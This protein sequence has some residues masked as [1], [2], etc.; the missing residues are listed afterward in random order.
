M[1]TTSSIVIENTSTNPDAESPIILDNSYKGDDLTRRCAEIL[2][3]SD[4]QG[5]S[6]VDSE[7][8]T[9]LVHYRED[10]DKTRYGHIRGLFLDLEVG[11]IIADSFGYTPTAVA[12]ELTL[13]D[14]VLTV[15]DKEGDNHV[16]SLE[17]AV[18]KRVFEGVVIRVIW[19]K[20]VMRRITH[21]KINPCKSRWG[22]SKSFITM[23]D[24]A[25]GPTAEQL[26]DTSKPYSS[27]CYDFLV[28]DQCLLVGT[29]QIVT[30]PYIVCFACRTMDIK[31]PTEETAPG[32]A[33]FTTTDITG[34]LI[35]GSI[36]HDPKCLSL[37]EANH[38]LQFGY[39]SP[40]SIDDVRQLT[41]EA[42]I[43]YK[44]TDDVVTDIVKVHSPSYEWRVNMRGNNPNI[45]NQFY[46]LLNSVYG[47][48]NSSD[49]WNAFKGKFITLPLYDE[50]SLKD[51]YAQNH[52]ILTI[53]SGETSSIDYNTRDS[54]IHLLWMN[55][56]LS[57]PAHIQGDGLNI[58][59]NFRTDRND[60]VTWLQNLEASN[61]NIESTEFSERVKGLI[62]SSRKLARA[63][64]SKGENY[65]A[66][67]S[68]MR[69]PVLIK[70]TL[71]NL[72]NKEKGPS[73]YSLVREMKLARK[74]ANTTTT[75][76]AETTETTSVDTPAVL[77]ETIV[78][79][80]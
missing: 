42:V 16:F 12:S 55:Y 33:T 58:L 15:L 57:L 64:I 9:A 29:R 49:L 52:V 7:E 59:S 51:L 18:I 68:Y 46:S 14:G 60:L 65:S 13:S 79:A 76:T 44:M 32:L 63:R 75:D 36:I 19:R 48:I 25:G 74:T 8:D 43:I 47:D 70:T 54:R 71:R 39:Y 17:E 50:Q 67:G 3:I 24:E 45:T 72:I 26:F 37:D 61:K 11:A 78:T 6:V 41:G 66:K 31:R 1:A 27:T 21:R 30:S 2:G 34:G 62:I 77:Q 28:V 69:L 4:I 38:H 73:L 22:S 40:F 10:S 80:L 56:V 53:P 35:N 5:W 20:G 23:Y